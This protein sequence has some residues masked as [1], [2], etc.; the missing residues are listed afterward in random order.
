MSEGTEK[1]QIEML[2]A[3]PPISAELRA[4]ILSDPN[5]EKLAK[6]LG[7]DLETYVNTIGY[8]INNPDV[9]P[10]LLQA[11]DDDIR[12]TIGI[13]PPTFEAITAALKAANDAFMS[14]PEAPSAFVDQRRPSIEIPKEGG[15]QPVQTGPADPKLVDAIKKGRLPSKG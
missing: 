10:A 1:P 13:E 14:G 15:D 5:V 12:K 8:Y 7:Q 2:D 11:S 4:K 3:P 6:E 9:E